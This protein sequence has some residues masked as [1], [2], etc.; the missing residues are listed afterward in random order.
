M[1]IWRWS[2]QNTFGMWTVLYWTRSSRTQFGVSTN[3]WRLAGDTFNITCN[4]LYCNHQVHRDFL[5]T[6]YLVRIFFFFLWRRGPMRAVASSFFRF[7]DHTQRRN[8]V[9]RFSLDECST[10]RRVPYL[11]TRNTHNRQ[12]IHAPAGFELSKRTTLR[13]CGH[14][15][16]RSFKETGKNRYY[17]PINIPVSTACSVSH[18]LRS[19]TISD[20]DTVSVILGAKMRVTHGL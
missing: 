20:D 5:I 10:H 15:D 17:L 4:F 11:T 1:M 3:V 2:S 7:L 6:L 9:G 18:I 12:H 13:P 14:W 16:R 8:T 19:L